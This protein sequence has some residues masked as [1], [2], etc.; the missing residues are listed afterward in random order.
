MWSSAVLFDW[1]NISF[2]AFR[3][4]LSTPHHMWSIL[5]Q[6][7]W[8][9]FKKSPPAPRKQHVLVH[10][11]V[12][13]SQLCVENNVWGLLGSLAVWRQETSQNALKVHLYACRFIYEIN[14]GYLFE[15]Q[16][17]VWRCKAWLGEHQCGSCCGRSSVC[18]YQVFLCW[19]RNAKLSIPLH[20]LNVQSGAVE[21]QSLGICG[22][23]SPH[24]SYYPPKL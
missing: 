9:A 12:N 19:G 20:L 18:R 14:S 13:S 22:L 23:S 4:L 11:S 2:S 8:L 7:L 16:M 17:L 1:W 10:V 6:I 15:S 21:N 3:I 5:Q 24:S